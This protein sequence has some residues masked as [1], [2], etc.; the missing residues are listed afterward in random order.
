M[1]K[2][3][4]THANQ[5]QDKDVQKSHIVR[6]SWSTFLSTEYSRYLLN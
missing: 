2:W 1:V 3:K 6:I 4:E 5:E